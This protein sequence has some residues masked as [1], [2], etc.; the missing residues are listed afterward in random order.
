MGV[1]LWIAIFQKY[2]FPVLSICSMPVIQ[3]CIYQK[4]FFM[5]WV[6]GDENS[7]LCIK[8]P[9]KFCAYFNLFTQPP[10]F[11]VTLVETEAASK[12]GSVIKDLLCMDIGLWGRRPGFNVQLCHLL[13]MWHW[14]ELV[15]ISPPILHLPTRN[16]N[17]CLVE[18][19]G[20]LNEH[21][22]K[23]LIQCLGG[24]GTSTNVCQINSFL[25]HKQWKLTKTWVTLLC[26][27]W[28]LLC[29]LWWYLLLQSPHSLVLVFLL[30]SVAL[31]WNN[32]VLLWN[33][34]ECVCN[35][36][37]LSLGL[38]GHGNNLESLPFKCHI[39]SL[40]VW[41]M[42]NSHGGASVQHHPSSWKVPT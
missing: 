24:S 5:G 1:R 34:Y 31:G 19:L 32:L 12:V 20:G 22:C 26:F 7:L 13:T 21:T 3:L 16:N 40:A 28:R 6:L 25:E 39:L 14:G 33:I 23:S 41:G 17:T 36:V 38:W 42:F 18:L 37:S 10:S 2:S 29:L 27:E 9:N 4:C 35:V 11:S 8:Q 30:P 15:N